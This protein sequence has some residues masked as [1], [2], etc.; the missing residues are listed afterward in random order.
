MQIRDAHVVITGASRGVGAALARALHQ[1]GAR[2]SLLARSASLSEL[3]R[4]LDARAYT[5]D[6]GDPS[7]LSTLVDRIEADSGPIDALIN[8]AAV[9]R[10][11]SFLSM[12]A[13]E[14]REHVLTNL[15]SPMELCRL[16]TPRMLERQRGHLLTISSVAGEVAARNVAAYSA[17]KSGI[18]QFTEVLQREIKR[19]PVKASVLVLGEI[20]T[21]MLVEGRKDPLL[22]A[23][24]NRIGA[25]GTLTP[26]SVAESAIEMLESDVALRVRPRVA[27]PMVYLRRLPTKL[28]DLAMAGL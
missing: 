23:V 28:M 7:G 21:Q 8:N 11:G 5:V 4:E 25:M 14:L 16:V 19:S 10:A 6:L 27:A 2:L 18:T 15:L 22:A 13:A 24:A 1:R 9:A 26:E 17:T 20:Q 12:S 3:A